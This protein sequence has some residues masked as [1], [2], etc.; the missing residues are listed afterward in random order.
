ML[1]IKILQ[2]CV[3]CGLCIQ[4]CPTKCLM[5]KNGK[6]VYISTDNCSLCSH[7]FSICPV[8]AIEIF[9]IKAADEVVDRNRINEVNTIVRYRRSIRS[10]DPRPLPRDKIYSIVEMVKFSPSWNNRRSV[11]YLILNRNKLDDLGALIAHS[12][13]AQNPRIL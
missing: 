12:M 11:R 2:S 8:G 13:V 10:Y 4:H 1:P 9:K 7:C 3:G 5:L 6:R